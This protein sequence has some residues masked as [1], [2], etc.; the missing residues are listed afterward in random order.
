MLYLAQENVIHLYIFCF[1]VAM[2]MEFLNCASNDMF[3][4]HSVVVNAASYIEAGQVSDRLQTRVA[5]YIHTDT[6]SSRH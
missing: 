2:E 4:E 1:Q 3:L 5:T 6:Y